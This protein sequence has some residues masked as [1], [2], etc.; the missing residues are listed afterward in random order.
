MQIYRTLTQTRVI[1]SIGLLSTVIAGCA[2]NTAQQQIENVLDDQVTAW[3]RGDIES[4]MQGYWQSDELTFEAPDSVTKGWQATLERYQR[5]YP[6]RAVMGTLT[7]SN[8]VVDVTSQDD[9]TVTG[10]YHLERAT[11]P[12][13]N[14]HFVLSLHRF[15]EGWRIV[16]DRTWSDS[17]EKDNAS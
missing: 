8:L 11:L 17:N 7:F 14:G 1:L 12:Q 15:E 10:R 3:N 5:R 16:R 6:N 13:A 9:A 2:Q 4:F